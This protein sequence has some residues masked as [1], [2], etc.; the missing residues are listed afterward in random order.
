MNES[1]PPSEAEQR[2]VEKVLAELASAFNRH[3]VEYLV[4][5]GNALKQHAPVK[6]DYIERG[7]TVVP[8]ERVF[9]GTRDID[10]WVKPGVENAL[11]VSEALFEFDK[12]Q[13]KMLALGALK[14]PTGWH[15]ITH[16]PTGIRIDLLAAISGHELIGG[17]DDARNNQIVREVEGVP[18]RFISNHHQL[19]NKLSSWSE[20]REKDQQDAR[21]LLAADRRTIAG[22]NPPPS[23]HDPTTPDRSKLPD[24]SESGLRDVLVELSP[25]SIFPDAT[26]ENSVGNGRAIE[27]EAI[28]TG[29]EKPTVRDREVFGAFIAALNDSKHR[30]LLVGDAACIPHVGIRP[31]SKLD[32]WVSPDVEEFNEDDHNWLMTK[33]FDT[34]PTDSIKQR[35]L[36][37]KI[38][39]HNEL[40]G[41]NFESAYDRRMAKTLY[42]QQASLVCGDDLVALKLGAGIEAE[43]QD[44]R[45]VLQALRGNREPGQTPNTEPDQGPDRERQKPG[46]YLVP[47]PEL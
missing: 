18:V 23:E 36:E 45:T 9:R 8:Q 26:P 10:V 21:D 11:R 1:N 43:T 37:S 38:Q 15:P 46:L 47:E 30:Y 31:V 32:V 14:D 39:I 2:Q 34:L 20:H 12:T 7:G 19:I 33:A 41:P 42:G 28:P 6:I 29:D 22:P 24:L 16:G 40:Q 13:I 35:D 27:V 5:G 17:F 4:V 25:P 44:A 3:G